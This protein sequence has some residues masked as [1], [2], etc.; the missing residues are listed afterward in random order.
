MIQFALGLAA[1]A[2]VGLALEWLVDWR[3]LV[4]G[5]KAEALKTE[6]V[7]RQRGNVDTST[8]FRPEGEGRETV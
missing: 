5:R 2:V 7:L 3:S 1:G 6:P 4:P 8:D